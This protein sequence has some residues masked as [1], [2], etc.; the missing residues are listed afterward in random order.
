MGVDLERELRELEPELVSA[1]IKTA[2]ASPAERVYCLALEFYLEAE[3]SSLL[4]V[5]IRLGLE[6]DRVAR[7]PAR[8][9]ADVWDPHEHAIDLT[10]IWLQVRTV[11]A[12]QRAQTLA[13]TLVEEDQEEQA[14]HLFISVARTLNERGWRPRNATADFVVYA[15]EMSLDSLDHDLRKSIPPDRWR[16]LVDA[17]YIDPSGL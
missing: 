3:A 6:R 10:D 16:Q 2:E 4:D 8:G 5:E 9:W 7:D 11:D 1:V 15:T 14:A 12:R 17:G 13:R